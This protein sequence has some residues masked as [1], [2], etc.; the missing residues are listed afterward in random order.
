M[1]RQ[2][3]FNYLYRRKRDLEKLTYT[4]NDEEIKILATEEIHALNQALDCMLD[5]F[6]GRASYEDEKVST[7]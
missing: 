3:S 2:E 1:T 7:K 4:T 6:E 5:I